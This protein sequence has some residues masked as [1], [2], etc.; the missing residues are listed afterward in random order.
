MKS[1]LFKKSNII[2]V[3]TLLV[4][5]TIISILL[6]NNIF[7][8]MDS[9][10]GYYPSKEELNIIYSEV[11]ERNSKMM[12]NPIEYGDKFCSSYVSTQK[13]FELHNQILNKIQNLSDEICKGAETDYEKVRLIAYWV[14]DY[15]LQP[16]C[17]F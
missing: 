2:I 5:A 14:A 9:Y 12:E 4:I 11:I 7:L 8:D 3:I 15:I 16:C 17:S 10:T 6:N 13:D 1:N